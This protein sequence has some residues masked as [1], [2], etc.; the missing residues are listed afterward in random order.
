MLRKL[1]QLLL[2]LS[3]EPSRALPYSSDRPEHRH[4]RSVGYLA[5]RFG[6]PCEAPLSVAESEHHIFVE[7]WRDGEAMRKRHAG[8]DAR[9]ASSQ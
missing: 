2:G 9:Q 4:A 1:Q 8:L 6:D 3:P 5:G 7:G